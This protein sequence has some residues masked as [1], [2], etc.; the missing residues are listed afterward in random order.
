MLG[1]QSADSSDVSAPGRK[2]QF[3]RRVFHAFNIPRRVSRRNPVV[4][5]RGTRTQE[6][7]VFDFW[8]FGWG[9]VLFR[10]EEFQIW[11]MGLARVTRVSLFRFSGY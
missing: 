4:T 7:E 6:R 5:L 1:K 9:G 3:V 11:C 8:A 2:Q 10:E